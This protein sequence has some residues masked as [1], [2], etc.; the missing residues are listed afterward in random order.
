MHQQGFGTLLRRNTERHYSDL[1]P[2]ACKRNCFLYLLVGL[3]LA[4]MADHWEMQRICDSLEVT[5]VY[6][7]DALL[8]GEKHKNGHDQRILAALE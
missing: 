6:P 4:P 2:Y 5:R 8:W 7:G 3:C 1:A